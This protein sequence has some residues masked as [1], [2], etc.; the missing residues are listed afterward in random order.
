[1]VVVHYHRR[2]A[3]YSSRGLFAFDGKTKLPVPFVTWKDPLPPTGQDDF[4]AYW[5]LRGSSFRSGIAAVAAG[6]YGKSNDHPGTEDQGF[7]MEGV[8]AK[9]FALSRSREVWMNDDDPVLHFTKED[10]VAAQPK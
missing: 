1:L 3:D 6:T 7:G 5:T 10:A 9:S 8:G 2:K 4:G